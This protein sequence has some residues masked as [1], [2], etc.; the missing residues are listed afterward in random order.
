[1][2]V[3]RPSAWS[4]AAL[5]LAFA[6]S[7]AAQPAD[8][9][10]RHLRDH[11][12][13]AFTVTVDADGA[14]VCEPASP[15]E[16][17]TLRRA[18][19]APALTVLPS[20][21]PPEALGGLRIVLRATDQLLE[22]PDA[23]LSFR[24]AAARWERAVRTPITVVYDIDYGPERFG[25]GP[26]SPST[27]ASAN[28]AA[29]VARTAGGALASVQTI[30]DSLKARTRDA[31]LL[32]LYDAIPIP[33]PSTA[34]DD[35]GAPVPLGIPFGAQP[36]L[37]AL[38]FLPAALDPDPDA[39]PFGN[40]PN[41]GF[42][43][44]FDFDF[45]PTDGIEADLIDF[46]AIV[47]HEMGHSLGFTSAIGIGGPPNNFFTIWDLFRVRPEDVVPGESL[48]DGAGWETAPRVVT[49]GPPPDEV[50][51]VVGGTTFFLATQVFFDGLGEYETSTATGAREGGDGQQAS[52]W[53]DDSQRPPTPRDSGDRYI[54]IM[55]PNF[56]PGV[57]QLYKEP[58][59][60]VLEVL[61]YDIDYSPVL[62][63]SLA[64]S[65]GGEAVD[66][67]AFVLDEIPL[68][69]VAP[70]ATRA[71]PIRITNPDAATAL[72][73]DVEV[74]V[75]GRFP[76]AN[77]ATLTLDV[78]E[79]TVAPGAS[80]TV[81]ATIGGPE[82]A[83]VFGRLRIRTN[84]DGR[85]VVEVPFTFSVGGG[86]EPQLVL[87]ESDGT[88]DGNL[89]ALG[90]LSGEERASA[91]FTIANPSNLDLRYEVLTGLRTRRFPLRTGEASRSAAS[92][93]ALQAFVGTRRA[94]EAA[95]LFSADF[96]SNADFARF[97][98]GGAING[99]WQR[100]TGGQAASGNHSTP[101]AA[102]FGTIAN[103]VYAY[104]DN[105]SGDLVTPPIDVSGLDPS[106]LVVVSFN[107][108]LDA[109]EPDLANG[110]VYDF[111]TVLYSVDGGETF[112]EVASNDIGGLLSNTAEW[113]S[114]MVSVPAVSGIPDP[115]QFAFR[116]TS[117]GGVTAEGW[118]LD[119]IEVS[120][121]AGGNGFFVTPRTGTINAADGEQTVTLTANAGPLERQFY[122]GVV[123]VLTDQRPDDPA[124]LRV[125]FSVDDPVL[126][127]LGTDLVDAL[128]TAVDGASDGAA[129]FAIRNEGSA[130]LSYIRVLEPALSR[131]PPPA[132]L[133]RRPP[134][135]VVA[136]RAVT[137]DVWTG[138]APTARASQPDGDVLG[139]VALPGATFALGLTQLA[140]GRVLAVEVG[141]EGAAARSFLA[142]ADL[143]SVETLGTV[144]PGDQILAVAYNAQTES[145]WYASFGEGNLFEVEIATDG[146]LSRTGRTVELGFPAAALA[147]SDALDAFFLIPF[148]SDVVLA[149]TADGA[150]L[151]GYPQPFQRASF[152]QGLSVS[153]G[154]LEI[155]FQDEANGGGSQSTYLQ[156]DQF[157]RPTTGVPVAVPSSDLGGASGV[158]GHV[159]SR[160]APDS[161]FYYLTSA[162]SD[163]V[164][165]IVAVDPPDL[166]AGTQTVVQAAAPFFAL[167][168]ESGEETR[169]QLR[170]TARGAEGDVVR[171]TI[172]ILTNNPAAPIVREPVRITVGLDTDGGDAPGVPAAFAVQGAFPNPASSR[173][174]VALDLPAESAVTVALYD[175]LGRRVGPEQTVT[176]PAG[177]G[178]RA[179][180]PP[181]PDRSVTLDVEG[182]AA[183]LY[184]VRVR[185]GEADLVH[186]ITVVR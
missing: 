27:I 74:V 82:R 37:Q 53:R 174:R 176:L 137:D 158:R 58:D 118:Y 32:A 65:V 54:G 139:S 76:A 113:T 75:D 39:T 8:G 181:D 148:N 77:A 124:P 35:G 165:R 62:A 105:A 12:A 21:N 114:V 133:T 177:F 29:T 169:A 36:T 98:S 103:G 132:A 107:M 79:G 19:A 2:V 9:L 112:R 80:R 23:L 102:Y 163:G 178:R 68:G 44:A 38:G 3:P 122:E 108:F 156:Y 78:A 130:P 110:V 146:S 52:H 143:S 117:H 173:V 61:G 161:V 140:D 71:V 121:V 172:S 170:L 142:P 134:P 45:D 123:Q 141:S 185:A 91:S 67:G 129:S 7:A 95:V 86:E 111:A 84:A 72:A 109:E 83:F 126:P 6:S 157:V 48:T 63:S 10:D 168:L 56:G 186:R 155:G 4:L 164:V 175:V 180:G 41:L 26:F 42:N 25:Q 55:D 127:T 166:P 51:Q 28:G 49:P 153:G 99:M 31:Q 24:R 154:V 43:S 138:P 18:G 162:G 50:D 34:T 160:A 85:L 116:F 1:M 101:G 136:G 149:Y 179:G 94:A 11:A 73:F 14:A 33:T 57:R 182:L 17:A 97:E 171:D 81:Q 135:A 46:E 69:D 115:V 100:T 87:R 40:V 159:R 88:D 104:R 16:G 106:D 145:L 59:L 15:E 183:G 150:A 70:A 66:L 60:R 89:G 93:R 92:T 47:I 167:D 90:D 152:Y 22:R 184:L 20:L 144:A 125:T 128:F 151:P 64:L 147:Y 5:A 119:D 131:A 13:G 120:S 96:A 30:V